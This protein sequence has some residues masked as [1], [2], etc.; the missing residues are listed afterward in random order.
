[1]IEFRRKVY[2]A[3]LRDQGFSGS[4]RGP[5]TIGLFDDWSI[6]DMVATREAGELAKTGVKGDVVEDDVLIQVYETLDE[7]D[8]AQKEALRASAM[9]KLTKAELDAIRS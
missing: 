2:K 3:I 6:A 7:F 9:K 4:V 8:K 5:L 1:M